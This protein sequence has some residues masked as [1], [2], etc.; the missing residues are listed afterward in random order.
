MRVDFNTLPDQAKVWLYQCSR[1]LQKAEIT[2]I[3]NVAEEFLSDWESHGI[4]VEGAIDVVKDHF[5]R[6]AAFTDEPSMCGRA[7]D[8]QVNFVKEIELKLSLVLTDRLE[9]AFDIGNVINIIQMNA[10]ETNIS[11]GTITA[12]TVFFDNLVSSKAEFLN[13]WSVPASASWLD[14]FF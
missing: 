8:A 2:A 7:Q 9:L 10:I 4:P 3:R 1:P 5:I 13:S 6:I 11:E 14:R 12:E